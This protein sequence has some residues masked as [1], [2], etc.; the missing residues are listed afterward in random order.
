[1]GRL[2]TL[3]ERGLVSEEEAETSKST[4]EIYRLNAAAAEAGLQ[5]VKTGS[6]KE[7]IALC[8]SRID[9]LEEEIK[10]VRRRLEHL[11]VVSPLSGVV[12]RS[13]WADTLVAAADTTSYVVVMPVRW[14][15]RHYLAPLQEVTV[16]IAGLSPP[17]YG[18]LA[19]LGGEAQ[20][21][22]G[23]QILLATA[24]VSGARGLA[25]GLMAQCSIACDPTPLLEY[26]RRT[27]ASVFAW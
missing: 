14:E 11:T 2:R 9:A 25:P 8:Q 3:R 20:I 23:R 21:L 12:L 18:K 15:D 26:L 19:Q 17:P 10:T 7:Q 16:N 1:M 5:S 22:A 27:L 6:K 13:F 4:L 24:T